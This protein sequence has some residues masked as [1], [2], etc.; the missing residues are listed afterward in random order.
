MSTS[1]TPNMQLVLPTPSSEPGP[2]WATEVNNALTAVDAHDHS[3]GKGVPVTPAGLNINADLSCN[4]NGLT[5]VKRVNLVQNAG[6]VALDLYTDGNDLFFRDGIGNLIK[7]TGSG[8]LNVTTAR[9]IGGDYSTDGANP[10]LYYTTANKEYSA[11]IN[12]SILAGLR[13][14]QLKTTVLAPASAATLTVADNDGTYLLLVTTAS[15]AVAVTLPAPG[16]LNTGRILVIKDKSGNAQVNNITISASG[17][18]TIDGSASKVINT[19]YGRIALQSD[20][21]NWWVIG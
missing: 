13:G 5:S 4:S 6:P 16:A 10:S 20:G 2:A 17:G 14:S 19:L 9:G 12:G 18:S 15:L 1:T 3:S 21:T 11:T 7:I 8:A